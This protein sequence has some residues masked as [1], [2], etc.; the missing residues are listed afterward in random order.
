MAVGVKSEIKKPRELSLVAVNPS[1]NSMQLVEH[2]INVVHVP[3]SISATKKHAFQMMSPMKSVSTLL[4]SVLAVKP[5]L[6]NV[7]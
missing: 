5:T 1:I 6:T 3:L 7:K 2:G 4:L